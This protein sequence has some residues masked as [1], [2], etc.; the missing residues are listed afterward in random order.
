[1]DAGNEIGLITLEFVF[2]KSVSSWL[3]KTGSSG[4]RLLPDYCLLNTATLSGGEE[5]TPG[6]GATLK[7]SHR[8]LSNILRGRLK[9]CNTLKG[10][11]KPY[12]TVRGRWQNRRLAMAVE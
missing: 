6:G 10:R 4:Q 12:N 5:A 11:L 1:M 7:H 8:G 9:H 3:C 2:D